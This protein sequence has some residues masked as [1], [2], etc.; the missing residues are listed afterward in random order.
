MQSAFS[1]AFESVFEEAYGD[2]VSQYAILDENLDAI[3]DELGNVIEEE[4]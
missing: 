2:D 4:F 3:T 1:S